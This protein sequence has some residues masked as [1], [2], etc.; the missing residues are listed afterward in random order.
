MAS[1]ILSTFSTA[2]QR[3]KPQEGKNGDISFREIE[4]FLP[5]VRTLKGALY[6]QYNISPTLGKQFGLEWKQRPMDSTFSPPL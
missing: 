4:F 5:E 1:L 6:P 2:I 3:L